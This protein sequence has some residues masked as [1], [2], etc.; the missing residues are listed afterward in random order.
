MAKID[1]IFGYRN[2]WFVAKNVDVCSVLQVFP[3]LSNI[4]NISWKEGMLEIEN[5]RFKIFISGIYEGWT[6]MISR[7][8]YDPSEVESITDL[9]L[10]IGKIAEEVCYFSSYR[11]VE[12][13]GFAKIVQGKII[14]MYCYSGEKGCIYKNMGKKTDAEKRLALNF[15]ANED[16][17]FE[18]GFHEI[19]EDDI[20]KLAGELSLNPESLI[21]MEEKQSLIADFL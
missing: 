1:Y 13:Y 3:N 20:L 10:K 18:E 12:T 6:F 15:A 14:R 11:T 4:R 17:L 5:L 9:L 21:G 19:D 8:L 16:E 7:D 2:T